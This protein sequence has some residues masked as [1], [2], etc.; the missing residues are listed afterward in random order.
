MNSN[1]C[2]YFLAIIS[3]VLVG[4]VSA[5]SES[6][7]NPIL[8]AD[9]PDMAVIRVDDTYYM[10]STTMHMSPGVPIMKSHDLVDWKLVKSTVSTAPS[11]CRLVS[12]CRWLTR[13]PISWVTASRCSTLQ[14]RRT[15]V[16]STLTSFG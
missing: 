11:G 3:A 15:V 8:W 1:A 9:V 12:R 7:R 13:Y 16:S 14:R 4:H 10:S 6:A 2:T 5:Q